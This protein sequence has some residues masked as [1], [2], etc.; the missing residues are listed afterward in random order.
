MLWWWH[1]K[2]CIKWFICIVFH[3]NTVICILKMK[4][5]RLQKTSNLSRSI[6]TK[7]WLIPKPADTSSVSVIL[8]LLCRPDH[9]VRHH[10][11]SSGEETACCPL[12]FLLFI[13]TEIIQNLLSRLIHT[14]QTQHF[15]K[16]M[17]FK[18]ESSSSSVWGLGEHWV[19][20]GPRKWSR[21]QRHPS[22]FIR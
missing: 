4:K 8:G 2:L 15:Y 1:I 16:I 7:A 12:L 10:Q 21:L 9:N 3:E 17:K 14:L 11:L 20:T 13:Y 22:P 5:Q 19:I 18:S 6:E